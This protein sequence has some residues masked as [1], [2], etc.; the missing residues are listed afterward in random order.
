MNTFE[1]NGTEVCTSFLTQMSFRAACCEFLV[2][3]TPQN[4]HVALEAFKKGSNFS[5]LCVSGIADLSFLADFPNLR[6]LEVI[7]QKRVNTRPIDGLSNLRGLRLES[8]GTGIDFSYFP[9]LEVFVGDW[10]SDNSNVRRCEELRQLRVW[11]FKPKSLDLS[12]LANITR[13]EWLDL[14]QT[15]IVSLAG[16]ETLPDLRYC[17]ISYAPKLES[18]A[19]LTSDGIEL[20]ELSIE[21]SKKIVSYEPIAALRSLR[22]L[23]LSDCASMPDLKWT[24]GLDQLDF[25]SFV[26]TNVEDGDLWPLLQLPKLRYVG[27]SDKK[28]Y[29]YRFAAINEILA[30]RTQTDVRK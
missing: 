23:K 5:G 15:G 20:R 26:E 24:K 21:K 8:P 6:Y 17:Q 1:L 11:Q 27:T 3:V 16:L 29:N 18:L 13:L 4:Q 2:S 12:D 9:E 28:H 22:R 30:Q 7:D 19:A 10:H 14:T 25:F